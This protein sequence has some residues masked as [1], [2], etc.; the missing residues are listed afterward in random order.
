MK[1]LLQIQDYEIW[2]NLGC[3]ADEQA[4]KQPVHV[5][6]ILEFTALVKGAASDELQDTTDYVFLTKMIAEVAS[7]KPYK[8]IEHLND[9]I[10]NAILHDLRS[11]YFKGKVR[12]SV[13]KIRVPVEN[14]RN[15]VVF[16][17]R[18]R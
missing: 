14:L 15:G 13:K 7:A 3:L 4:N 10:M 12:L 9:S 5:S 2:V 17:C 18:R 1:H 11:T 16:E 6:L 8:L